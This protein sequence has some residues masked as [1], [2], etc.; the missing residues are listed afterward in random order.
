RQ[1]VRGGPAGGEIQVIKA[2][3][4][5]FFVA[6][7]LSGSTFAQPRDHNRDL[8]PKPAGR[9]MDF[10]KADIHKFCEAADLKQE[11]L[12]AHWSK[13]SSRCQDVLAAPMRDGGDSNN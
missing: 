4:A 1:H 9:G 2:G 3:Y 7:L 5:F 8:P 6:M 13:I 11:C 12:V 10:C